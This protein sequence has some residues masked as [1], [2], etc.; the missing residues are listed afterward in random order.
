MTTHTPGPWCAQGNSVTASGRSVAVV[1]G[2]GSRAELDANA[3]LI[4][5]AP[6]LLAALR[7]MLDTFGDADD[8][9]VIDAARAALAMVQP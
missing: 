6:D 7:L 4:A 1:R 3:R 8:Q 2:R 5:A 9:S